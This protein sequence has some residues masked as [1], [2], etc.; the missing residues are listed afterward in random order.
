METEG[1]KSEGTRRNIHFYY[2][3]NSIVNKR[4]RKQAPIR[5]YLKLISN[6]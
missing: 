5:D 4:K 3:F 6:M 2:T 1:S